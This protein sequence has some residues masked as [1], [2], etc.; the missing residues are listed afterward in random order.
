MLTIKGIPIIERII[1][2]FK[3]QGFKNFLIS[4][5]YLGHKIKKHLCNGE[6]LKVNINYINEHSFLGTAGSLS[7]IDFKKKICSPSFP[8]ISPNKL[9]FTQKMFFELKRKTFRF[10]FQSRM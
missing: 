8:F 2:N 6:K 1:I 9:R 10:D 7:L 3:K 4:V 5:N